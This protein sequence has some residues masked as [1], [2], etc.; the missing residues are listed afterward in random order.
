M[1]DETAHGPQ[2]GPGGPET[3]PA[4]QEATPAWREA[5][6][7]VE[8]QGRPFGKAYVVRLERPEEQA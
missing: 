7:A 1:N 2:D 6:E 5:Q 8:R 4:A 3:P